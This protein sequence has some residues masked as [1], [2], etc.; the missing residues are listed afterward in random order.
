MLPDIEDFSQQQENPD[1]QQ[2]SFTEQ[3]VEEYIL[4]QKKK[5]ETR[6]LISEMLFFVSCEVA[7]ASLA[8]VLFQFAVQVVFTTWLCL[9]IAWI[10]SLS[11][12][13]EVNFQKTDDGWTLRIMNKPFVAIFKFVTGVGITW[14]TIH[15]VHAEIMASQKAIY[16]VY[17]AI[18]RYESPDPQNFLPP[19]ALQGLFG[20]VAIVSVITLLKYLRD[21]TPFD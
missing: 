6:K 5:L 17:E 13:C 3:F 15:A 12:L 14:F 9:F 21:R 16:E 19:F 7:S 1:A 2:D 8:I 4:I 11:S 20:A 18:E 10:P